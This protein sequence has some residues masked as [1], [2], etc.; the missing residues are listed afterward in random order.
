MSHQGMSLQ[1]IAA[2]LTEEGLLPADNSGQ[3]AALVA[4]LSGVQPWY[5]RAMV[6]FGAW[7][8]SLLIIGFIGSI[9]LAAKGGF[10]VVGLGLIVA[11]VVMRRRSAND[12]MVQSTL[13]ASLAGQAL[14]AYGIAELS[15]GDEWKIVL[16]AAIPI[17]AT[18][19]FVFP[20]RIHRVISVLIATTSLAILIYV[21]ELNAIVPFMGPVFAAAMVLLYKYQ[22]R[23]MADGRGALIRPLMTGLM[24]TAFGY[25][26]ISTI[27]VLPELGVE[28]A[29][30]PRPWIS[31]V[32][33]GALFV[34]LGVD[35]W[36]QLTSDLQKN[37]APV[38][39][40]L[41]LLVIAAAWAVPGLLLALIVTMLGATSGNRAFAGAGIVFLAVFVGTYFY[42]VQVTMLTK[43]ATLIASGLAILAA[44]WVLV[45]LMSED[46]THV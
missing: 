13:A 36:R 32:L 21:W 7:L 28:Y 33:L 6:G 17:S 35:V 16:M 42:G 45:R 31:T 34:Y 39:Y 12:F 26:M 18:L 1:D 11:A 15:G 22:A 29:F 4:S 37:A 46:S 40:G 43:S 9:G 14:M 20:D 25:L 2:R 27:Y 24:L 3:A 38:L 30:Y 5:V 23:I 41:M 8:S 10:L 44:R 19:F